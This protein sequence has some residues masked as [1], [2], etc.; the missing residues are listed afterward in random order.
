MPKKASINTELLLKHRFWIGVGVFAPLVLVVVCL[1]LFGVR[2]AVGS[3]QK[4][5]EAAK[6][7]IG[8]VPRPMMND[9]W[10]PVYQQRQQ[11]ADEKKN[12]IWAKAWNHQEPIMTWPKDMQEKAKGKAYGFKFDEDTRE[13][14]GNKLYQTQLAELP[15]LAQPEGSRTEVVQFK[16]EEWQKVLRFVGRWVKTPPDPEELWLAQEDLWIQRALLRA[17]REANESAGMMHRVEALAD[18]APAGDKPTTKDK[19]APKGDKPATPGKSAVKPAAG[20][21]AAPAESAAADGDVFVNHVWRLRLKLGTAPGKIF[22]RG[23]LTNLSDRRQTLPVQ[24]L[25]H[26]SDNQPP[27]LVSADGEPLAPNQSVDVEK[28]LRSLPDRID[29]VTQAFTWRNAPIKRIDRI[30][31]GARSCLHYEKALVPDAALSPVGEEPQGRTPSGLELNRYLEVTPAVRRMPIGILL[32]VDQRYL[33]EI[34]AAF[35]NSP[36]RMHVNEVQWQRLKEPIGPPA[37]KAVATVGAAAPPPAKA[38]P[39][40][41]GGN[42][43]DDDDTAQPA[44]GPGGKL[45]LPEEKVTDQVLLAFYGVANLYKPYAPPSAATPA[46]AAPAK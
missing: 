32:V 26:F 19:E 33:E 43:G 12:E 37:D 25:L 44:S 18:P 8:A 14:Y 7:Q 36:L 10:I 24:F 2:K 15:R 5:I 4:E 21:K 22:V 45:A 38:G 3:K 40:R 31:M 9:R 17:V 30:A 1:L 41:S 20:M 42:R 34:L 16:G 28:A 11:N 29:H 35:N 27:E 13:A 6:A 46:A 39:R 23:R